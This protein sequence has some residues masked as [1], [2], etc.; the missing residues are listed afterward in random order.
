MSADTG[1]SQRRKRITTHT[2][3]LAVVDPLTAM[4][5]RMHRHKLLKRRTLPAVFRASK[6]DALHD[7]ASTII[8]LVVIL[9]RKLLTSSLCHCAASRQLLTD[10][11]FPKLRRRTTFAVML[12]DDLRLA[13]CY[14]A[15]RDSDSSTIVRPHN[16]C[17]A[18]SFKLSK[19]T[20]S[21]P[22]P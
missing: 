1:T 2:G 12:L 4:C 20:R 7:V 17:H 13:A 9:S 3:R 22:F 6:R 11:P 18:S 15:I 16:G 8:C 5:S 21:I 19:L 10:K 14:S